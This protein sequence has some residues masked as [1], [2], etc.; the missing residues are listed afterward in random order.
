MECAELNQ[1]VND[2]PIFDTHSHMA[3][4][5]T[6]SPVNDKA[7]KTLPMILLND[8][9]LYLCWSCADAAPPDMGKGAGKVE[10]AE[11]DWKAIAPL[12]DKYR[13][14]TTYSVLR[15]G[16][17]ELYPFDEPDITDAN[18]RKINDQVLRAYRT[19]GERALQRQIVKRAG[20]VLQNQMCTLPYVTDHWDSLPPE[21]RAAQKKFLLP[22][23]ILDGYLFTG[24][25][26]A[27]P[28]RERTEELLN[29][30][31]RTHAEYLDFCAKALDL[32]VSKGGKSVKLLTAYHRTLHFSEVPDEEAA[33]LFSEGPTSLK[34]ERLQRLQDN[35]CWRLLEMCVAR[36]LPLIVH[37]GYATPTSFGDP[38]GMINLFTSKRLAGLN[39]DLCHSGWP[40]HGGGM[41]MARTYR[42]CYFN[43][44]WTPML[45]RSLGKR[46][47]S[48]AI[49]MLPMNKIL[50][51]TD[52]GS[53]ESFLGTTRLL[54]KVLREVLAEKVREGQF[55]TEV[56]KRVARAILFDNSAEFYRMP[57]D[58]VPTSPV[59][60]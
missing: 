45:S 1:Y 49:D 41:I 35:L 24:F 25:S 33:A 57:L 13:A 59:V 50:M 21:E 12:L 19:H 56:A 11:Q 16:L 46:I 38:E 54:R 3:G 23:L 53:A 17:R 6:G 51:G 26:T 31:P 27:R 20:V 47:L 32:F 7:G 8:Y 34:P 40:H 43:L 44:V 22:S 48:E 14:L 42:G 39:V 52:C 10:D 29:L 28:G 9:L 55:N 15:E 36:G 5:D 58:Q 4:F 37:T 60:G 18:W 2:L 30:H